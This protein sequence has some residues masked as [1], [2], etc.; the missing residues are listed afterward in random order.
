MS[1]LEK[2]QHGNR[3]KNYEEASRQVLIQGTPKIL[4]LDGKAFHTFLKNAKRPYDEYV[5]ISMIE[6]AKCVMREIGG[7]A[8]FAYIQSDECTIVINDK[9]TIYSEPWFANQIQ[10]IVSI[11]ASIMSVNFSSH[12]NVTKQYY[13]F[14]PAYFD[15]RF[16]QVPSIIEMHNCVLWR[17]FDASKNSISQYARYYFSHKDLQNKNGKEMQEMMMTEKGFNWNDAPTWT[18]RGVVI[19]R[20]EEMGI[21]EDWEIPKFNE[22]TTY[23]ITKYQKDEI[24]ENE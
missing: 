23:L 21:V 9:M 17:Q 12:Y 2:D 5:M 10:K 24:S 22:Q 13:D 14:K 15:A 16:F 3:M 18:K 19:Y 6:A 8:R 11:A 4:R 1:N 20:D 7:S